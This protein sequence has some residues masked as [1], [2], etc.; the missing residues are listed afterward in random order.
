MVNNFVYLVK[1]DDKYDVR[2]RSTVSDFVKDVET[3]NR[4][5]YELVKC[6]RTNG[7]LFGPTMSICQDFVEGYISLSEL[8]LNVIDLQKNS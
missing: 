6:F 5:G 8:E 2:Y 4:L 7:K 3:I 1:E